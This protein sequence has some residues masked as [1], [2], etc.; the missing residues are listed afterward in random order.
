M[1]TAVVSIYLFLFHKAIDSMA[2]YL[3]W[4]DY[5]PF[6]LPNSYC[7]F[8][9]RYLCRKYLHDSNRRCE[10]AWTQFVK[11]GSLCS[12]LR[13]K[14]RPANRTPPSVR[15]HE[16]LVKFV[17]HIQTQPLSRLLVLKYNRKCRCVEIIRLVYLSQ[18]PKKA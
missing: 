10:K 5:T 14:G 8:V 1:C 6:K 2:S 13:Q 15:F 12:E 11:I 4:F 17:P 16:L 7:L 18:K 3:S 9:P